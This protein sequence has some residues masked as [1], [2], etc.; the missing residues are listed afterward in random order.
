MQP[1][2]VSKS[3]TRSVG[4]LS[5]LTPMP[6][7]WARLDSPTHP[8]V[9][10]MKKSFLETSSSTDSTERGPA[11]ELLGKVGTVDIKIVLQ[12]SRILKLRSENWGRQREVCSG[13]PIA[14][15]VPRRLVSSNFE[16]VSRGPW[17]KNGALHSV[18]RVSDHAATSACSRTSL[19][20]W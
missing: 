13:S 6:G 11:N 1:A 19:R 18:I 9:R 12:R 7:D 17:K 20:R 3:L 8:S 10:C 15:P 14:D 2:G 5:S 4:R 16:D